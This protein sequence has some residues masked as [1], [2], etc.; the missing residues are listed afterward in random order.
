MSILLEHNEKPTLRLPFR[1]GQLSPVRDSVQYKA[2]VRRVDHVR[3]S[4]NRFYEFDLEAKRQIR[5][6]EHLP[7]SDSLWCACGELWP[8][9]RV[10]LVRDC[11][12]VG[13]AHEDCAVRSLALR[14]LC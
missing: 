1:I 13:L 9:P 8:H 11:E 4:L 3:Q 14:G 5:V 12:K 10:D 7:L 6:V 2:P